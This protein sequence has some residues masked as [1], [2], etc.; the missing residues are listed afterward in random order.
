MRTA[1]ERLRAA[2]DEKGLQLL[3]APA[4]LPPVLADPERLVQLLSGLLSNALRYTPA[5]TVRLTGRAEGRQVAISV[6]DTGIGIAPEQL[7][8]VFER[9]FRADPS[10]AR[11]SGG[12]GVGL[13]IALALATT[14]GGTLRAESGGLGKGSTFTLF[15]PI[16]A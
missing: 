16:A 2:F 8:H 9:F 13:T 6:D 15:L 12:S 10:R 4:D 3:V 7:P 11:A 5:G 1:A 14:M